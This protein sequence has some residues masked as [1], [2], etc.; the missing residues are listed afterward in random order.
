MLLRDI[1]VVGRRQVVVVRRTQ[2]TK[3]VGRK[4]EHAL[5]LDKTL[6]LEREF[7][8]AV[9]IVVLVVFLI[10][11][12]LVIAVIALCARFLHHRF[13]LGFRILVLWDLRFRH[14]GLLHGS[15]IVRLGLVILN[16]LRLCFLLGLAAAA[17][18][19]FLAI[20]TIFSSSNGSSF[21]GGCSRFFWLVGNGAFHWFGIV[22]RRLGTFCLA[23]RT[24][25]AAF[26]LCRLLL[27]SLYRCSF[28]GCLW[29]LGNGILLIAT[30][31]VIARI[32][33][34]GH[35]GHNWNFQ[36]ADVK[37]ERRLILFLFRF[38][39][40]GL[41]LTLNRL[42]GGAVV[43]LF[44]VRLIFLGVRIGNRNGFDACV[45]LALT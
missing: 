39:R 20:V 15:F 37:V 42:S 6:Y 10:V 11:L 30:L 13:A 35:C 33:Q 23:R 17:F 14:D 45:T 43:H 34:F 4:L 21:C 27:R 1:D 40:R 9:V 5:G 41:C 29:L 8:T 7:V 3:A 38:R 31:Q 28:N 19:L 25:T 44:L 36:V 16:S 26:L 24:S 2:E 32:S 22:L 12:L 18:L